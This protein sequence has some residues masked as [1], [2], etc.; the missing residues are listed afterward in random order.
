[1]SSGACY[2]SF[3]NNNDISN[4]KKIKLNTYDHYYVP[5]EAWHQIINPFDEPTHI[6]E[7]Q[8]GDECIEEDIERIG[9]V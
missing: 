1:M 4:I 9:E 8:Y 6:I 5:A 3:A 7:I 2:V